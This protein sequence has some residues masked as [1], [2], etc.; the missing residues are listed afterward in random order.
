MSTTTFVLIIAASAAVALGIHAA[1]YRYGPNPLPVDG[2]SAAGIIDRESEPWTCH[3][4]PNTPYTVAE[5]HE[6]MQDRINCRVDDCPAKA[7]A[8]GVLIDARIIT[9]ARVFPR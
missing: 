2:I 7:A 1:R 8:F 4:A 9:P 3:H 6:V 5:A